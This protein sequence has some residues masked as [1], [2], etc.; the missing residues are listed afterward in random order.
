MKLTYTMTA[1]AA[2]KDHNEWFPHFSNGKE[3]L[4]MSHENA[5]LILDLACQKAGTRDDV[6]WN[7]F[8]P[9]AKMVEEA[10]Q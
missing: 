7:D 3:F 6:Y 5:Q 8:G 1:Q 9:V 10:K 4:A 2:P